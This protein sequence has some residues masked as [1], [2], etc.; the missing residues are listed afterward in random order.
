MANRYN[1]G[2]IDT[3]KVKESIVASGGSVTVR[4][5]ADGSTHTTAYSRSEDRRV[6]WDTDK[7]GT[8]LV[9]IQAK[10]LDT[11]TTRVESDEFTGYAKSAWPFLLV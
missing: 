6:S 3:E 1:P 9:Y 8:V 4:E 11:S 2:T 10:V 5:R 7:D